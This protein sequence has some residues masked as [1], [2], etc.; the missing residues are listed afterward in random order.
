MARIAFIHELPIE[1]FV[2]WQDGLAAA[3]GKL[4]SKYEIFTF[5]AS[6]VDF[7]GLEDFD[8]I[9]AWGG[10]TSKPAK[11]ALE[12]I[13]PKKI[14]LYGG[15]LLNSN[16]SERFDAIFVEGEYDFEQLNH[17]N[18]H[19]AFGTNTALFKPIDQPKIFDMIYPTAFAEWKDHKK[20]I[21]LSKGKKALCVGQIQEN[22]RYI[23][24]EVQKAGIATLP[25]VP[26]SVMPYL[27]AQSKET[28]LTPKPLGGCERA[29]LESASCNVPIRL[30]TENP[31]C[32]QFARIKNREDVIANKLTEEDYAESLD[33]GIQGVINPYS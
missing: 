29:I 7:R 21:R 32:L 18:K 2:Y 20:F 10:V 33:R 30:E 22:E 11:L 24:E 12:S 15:G 26:Y 28:V 25:W 5:S 17:K 6:E 1:M 13:S 31:K 4:M 16:D 14:L 8:V 9:L 3:L 23:L 27:Y 19:I